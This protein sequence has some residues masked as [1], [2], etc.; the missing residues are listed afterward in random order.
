MKVDYMN[1]KIGIFSF[2][3]GAGFLDLGFENTG[4]YETLFANEYHQPFMD[5]YKGARENMGIKSPKY[6]HPRK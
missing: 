2:F 1:D 4:L 3:A 6:G 5:I